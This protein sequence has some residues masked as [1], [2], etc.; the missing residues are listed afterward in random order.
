MNRSRT[1][2]FQPLT[3]RPE[4]C[5]ETN[6]V[7]QFQFQ[8]QQLIFPA[9]D[10][11]R[12]PSLLLGAKTWLSHSLENK[13]PHD[14][15]RLGYKAEKGEKQRQGILQAWRYHKEII[16][17]STKTRGSGAVEIS[18]RQP[19]SGYLWLKWYLGLGT[20]IWEPPS[21]C[22]RQ[23]LIKTFFRPSLP[24]SFFYFFL[25]FLSHFLNSSSFRPPLP[26]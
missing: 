24:I 11:I 20:C 26:S 9:S 17:S 23:L 16:I 25:L 3:L 8:I 12:S 22:L 19:K 14:Q 1:C 21:F 13:S 18:S 15:L 4:T 5:T 2:R 6:S 7:I 10:Q